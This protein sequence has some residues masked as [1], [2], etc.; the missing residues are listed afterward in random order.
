MENNENMNNEIEVR[1]EMTYDN[2]VSSKRDSDMLLGIGIGAVLTLGVSKLAG[3][4]KKKYQNRKAAKA[5]KEEVET[6]IID[7]D[8]YTVE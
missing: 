7:E 4:A 2:N 5:K 8:D 6:E 3:F 1:E